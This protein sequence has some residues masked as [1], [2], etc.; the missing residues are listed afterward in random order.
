MNNIKINIAPSA[1]FCFGVKRAVDLV[2]K[3]LEHN[4]GTVY[5]W[6][7]LIHNPLIME[8]LKEKGLKVIDDLKNFKEGSIFV[9][10]SHG[11]TL[12]DLDLIKQKTSR[13]INTT[14]PFVKNAQN[15]AKYFKIKG[16]KILIV[17][18]S[19][20]VEVKGINSRANNEAFIISEVSELNKIKDNLVG[21]KVGVVCQT[22]QRKSKLKEIVSRLKELK[23]DFK[24]QD[25]ICLDSTQKQAEVK[26]NCERADLLI[27]IGGLCSSNTAK[28]AEIGR[29]SNLETYHIE[30]SKNISPEW[31]SSKSVVY[32][33]AGAST[34]LDELSKA[35][36]IIEH[37]DF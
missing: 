5:C 24:V 31:F 26:K 7:D 8:R 34:P 21:N 19:N 37:F 11:I 10:R 4:Q 13:I 35:K 16:L 32:I 17:G 18:D 12:E 3:T 22:T 1:G 15:Q 27:V 36:K 33:A 6:G 25:T 23:I 29:S 30:N 2:K 14:C 9:I 20:H 28:L